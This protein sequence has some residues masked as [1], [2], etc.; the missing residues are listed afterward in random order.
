VSSQHHRMGRNHLAHA[1]GDR[2]LQPSPPNRVVEVF[3]A[4][5]PDRARLSR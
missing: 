1:S 3:V 2:R 5:Y 4:Q